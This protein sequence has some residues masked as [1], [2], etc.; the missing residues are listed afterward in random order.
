MS[1]GGQ[2]SCSLCLASGISLLVFNEY[3]LNEKKKG[4][5]YGLHE[6]V[7][8]GYNFIFFQ[9]INHLSNSTY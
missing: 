3:F 9:M 1:P 4:H 5:L 6:D 8:L 7:E 2:I